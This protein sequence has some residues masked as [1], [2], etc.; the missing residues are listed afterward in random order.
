MATTWWLVIRRNPDREAIGIAEHVELE[1]Y[2]PGTGYI[3]KA[4]HW[5]A[6]MHTRLDEQIGPG[7]TYNT[8]SKA[9]FE[10]FRDLHGLEVLGE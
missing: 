8:I 1:E 3:S 5:L 2:G 10:T 4:D 6:T 7:W 9:E